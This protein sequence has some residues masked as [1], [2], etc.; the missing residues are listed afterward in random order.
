MGFRPG[1]RRQCS[2]HRRPL[3]KTTDEKQTEGHVYVRSLLTHKEYGIHRVPVSNDVRKAVMPVATV[4]APTTCPGASSGVVQACRDTVDCYSEG[5]VKL[6]AAS[7]RSLAAKQFHLDKTH[8]IDI[9]I[10]Q[11]DGPSQYLI[12]I[13]QFSLAGDNQKHAA[14]ANEFCF[15]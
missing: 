11:P 7:F 2:H 15:Q 10:A 3:S 12:V 9:R 1:S 4:T 6:D 13:E 8:G 14:S 5:I